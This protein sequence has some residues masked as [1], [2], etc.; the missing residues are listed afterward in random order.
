MAI[1]V[2]ISYQA[3]AVIDAGHAILPVTQEAA[4]S[5]LVIPAI[6]T[7]HLVPGP[8]A[9]RESTFCH[10]LHGVRG[11]MLGSYGGT[12]RGVLEGVRRMVPAITRRLRAV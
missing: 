8:F 12:Y 4:S 7:L 3:L 10:K 5:S 2:D 11:K 1:D 9:S 6:F